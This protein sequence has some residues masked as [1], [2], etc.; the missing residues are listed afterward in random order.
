MTRMEAVRELQTV[1]G[2]IDEVDRSLVGLMAARVDLAREARLL[3]DQGELSYEDPAREAAVVRQAAETA[4]ELE[5]DPEIIRDV[6]W[7]LIALSKWAH[8]RDPR[9]GAGV[10]AG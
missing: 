8:S 7:R 5:L 6:F 9:V 10:G 4:R 1:R 2:E 3:K